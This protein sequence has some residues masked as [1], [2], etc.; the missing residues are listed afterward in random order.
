MSKVVRS[1]RAKWYGMKP[2]QM[3]LLRCCATTYLKD[4][5]IRLATLT[6]EGLRYCDL[7]NP[8]LVAAKRKTNRDPR[9]QGPLP[10]HRRS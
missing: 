4:R 5:C 2:E 6:N 7:H 3:D 8:V 10:N 1:W 9:G